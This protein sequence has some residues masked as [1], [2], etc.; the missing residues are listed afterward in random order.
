METW[1]RFLRSDYAGG[2][3]VGVVV[4]KC[5]LYFASMALRIA[6]LEAP[7]LNICIASLATSIQIAQEYP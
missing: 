4:E 7:A 3:G 5:G 1:H 6:F 2:C